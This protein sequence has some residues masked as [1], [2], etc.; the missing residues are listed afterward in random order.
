MSGQLL[1][2]DHHGDDDRESGAGQRERKD[3]F[4]ADHLSIK[5]GAKV[6]AFEYLMNFGCSGS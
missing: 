1:K 3:V 2:G 6:L 5:Y 4:D